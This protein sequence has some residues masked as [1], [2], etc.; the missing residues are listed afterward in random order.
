MFQHI[1]MSWYTWW[2]T[3]HVYIVP[4]YQMWHTC[5]K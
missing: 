3:W 1:F 2:G 4:W 5:H